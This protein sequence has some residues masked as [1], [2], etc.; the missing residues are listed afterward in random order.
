MRVEIDA[1]HF[2]EPY[3]DVALPAQEMAQ[4]RRDIRR[5][6][7][8]RRNLVQQRLEE[9]M[10]RAIDERDADICARKRARRPQAA[11]TTAENHDMGHRHRRHLAGC[12]PIVA[13]FPEMPNG[14]SVACGKI[15]K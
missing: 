1:A 9:M 3:F 5:R 14:A 7:S 11:E 12:M 6:E 2:V 4:R 13:D 15:A 8:C 10:V